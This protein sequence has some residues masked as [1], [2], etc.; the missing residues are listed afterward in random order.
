[1]VQPASVITAGEGSRRRGGGGVSGVAAG[2]R[3][4]SGEKEEHEQQRQWRRW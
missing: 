1:M 4:E 3:L 2:L